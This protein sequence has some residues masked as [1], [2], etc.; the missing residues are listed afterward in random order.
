MAVKPSLFLVRKGTVIAAK[1]DVRRFS[2]LFYRT[3]RL[4]KIKLNSC[5]KW[6]KMKT[7]HRLNMDGKQA[8]D[9]GRTRMDLLYNIDFE[10]ASAV[11]VALIFFLLKTQYLKITKVNSSFSLV[12]LA[13]LLANVADIAV[14]LNVSYSGD[15]P[16]WVNMLVKSC[17]FASYAAIGYF[18]FLYTVVYI[19]DMDE[20]RQMKISGTCIYVLYLVLLLFNLWFGYIFSFNAPYTYVRGPLYV[21]TYLIPVLYLAASVWLMIK[22]RDRF[23]KTMKV[24]AGIFVFFAV[25]GPLIQEFLFPHILLGIFMP[26]MALLYSFFSLETPD[27]Q[28]LKDTMEDLVEAKEEALRADKSKSR[29]LAQMSHE[30]RTPINAI[31]GMNEMILRESNSDSILEYADNVQSAGRTLLSII[32]E[33]LDIS[34]LE[35]DKVEILP[36]KYDVSSL[37]NDMVNVISERAKKKGLELKL[38]IDPSLPGFMFGDDI[39][40]RQVITN[41]LTNSVKY[42]KKGTVT[43]QMRQKERDG[44][45]IILHVE[46]QDTGMGIRPEDMDKLFDSFRRLDEE[47][48]RNIEG[49][50]LGLPITNRL[51]LLM[52]SRLQVESVYGE[53]SRFWFELAQKVMSK[54]TIGDFDYRHR[55]SLAEKESERYIYAPE[56]SVLVVDD[57]EMNLKVAAG[58]LKRNGIVPDMVQSGKACIEAVGEKYYDI[59]FMD[60]MMPGM[61]GIETLKALLS[62]DKLPQSTV[63]VAMTAN[64]IVGA[65]EEYLREGFRD[66]ISKPI[67]VKKLEKQLSRYLPPEKVAYRETHKETPAGEKPKEISREERFSFL[68]TKTGLSYCDNDWEFYLEMLQSYVEE[69]KREDLQKD[70]EK[71]DTENYRILIHALKSTSLT[72]GAVE[73]SDRAKEL[74][75]AAKEGD[76]AFIEAHH[77]ECMEQY[78]KILAQIEV[79]ISVSGKDEP[80]AVETAEDDR[81]HILVVDD[82]LINLKMA[83]KLLEEKYRV[84]CAQSGP[85][86]ISFLRKHKTDLLLLDLHMPTMDGFKVIEKLKKEQLEDIPIIFLT[87]DDDQQAEVRGFQAGALDFIRKPF[88]GEIM[89]QR[90]QRILELSRLQK[91]LQEEVDRQIQ[92]VEQGHR[93]LEKL[94]SQMVLSL[95]NTI[96]AKDKYTNGH[97]ER[98]ANYSLEIAK[99]AGL[100]QKEQRETY[101]MALLHDIGKIGI[102]DSIIN[103]DS[104]LT[105][106]EYSIIKTHPAIGADI[107]KDIFEMPEIVFGARWHHERFGGGGYPDGI[108]GDEI[109]VSARIIGVADAYDAMTSKRSY[110]DVLE[111]DVVKEELAKGKGTQFDPVYADIMLQM[112]EED[113]EYHMRER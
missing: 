44:D 65:K 55:Q 48:N 43:F 11:L 15:F 69:S 111:Q 30:I 8:Q 106:N 27:Y 85:A 40:I 93:N 33:I 47:K 95:V 67:V 88:V 103:K 29:F 39:R 12:L 21:L 101:F 110:R 42:T 37:V 6:Y 112:M 73:L 77:S 36:V 75:Q 89:L 96:D 105:D 113:K 20:K 91:H 24:A 57:N 100:S 3:P 61:N 98:V 19:G 109:P 52:N 38:E 54:E 51:L 59:I 63:V 104:S 9:R 68:D 18:Y 60:Y 97:S 102:P 31:L 50:G 86:A 46:V 53:G 80:V 94:F 62:S 2:V 23:Q 74:E 87:A 25:A 5:G 76:I 99:R 58:L 56:A 1:T 34:K 13:A 45:T 107:L 81:P 78:E 26:S 66:Y 22:Y 83:Q 14:A 79:A 108:S 90:V 84:D 4:Y 64:A 41:L 10:I 82:D 35:N 16:R 71:K 49:T 72:I 7:K 28:R 32:N 70:Y 17:F 92:K